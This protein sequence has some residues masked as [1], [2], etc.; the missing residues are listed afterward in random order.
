MFRYRTRSTVF[1]TNIAT[2]IQNLEEHCQGVYVYI[3]IYCIE[4]GA[5][6]PVVVWYPKFQN[7]RVVS[8]TYY[9]DF[10]QKYVY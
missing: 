8:L 2:L 7:S 6:G 5:V 4:G 3:Y 1:I 9:D 10:K